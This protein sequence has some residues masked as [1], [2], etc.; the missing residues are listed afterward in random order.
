MP[1][2]LWGTKTFPV[3]GSAAAIVKMIALSPSALPGWQ[4][5][6]EALVQTSPRVVSLTFRP[7]VRMNFPSSLNF[8]IR[9]LESGPPLSLT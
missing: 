8:E 4:T 2:G 5:S 6:P 3:S 1:S 9:L 7:K